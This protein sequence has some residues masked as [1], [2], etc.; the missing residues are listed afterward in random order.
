MHQKISQSVGCD[1]CANPYA[2]V[3]ASHRSADKAPSTWDGENQKECVILFEESRLVNVV[4]RVKEPHGTVHKVFMGKPS[5]PLHA[6]E[7][8]NHNASS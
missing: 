3:S 2:E 8:A 5:N 1:S 6:N 7:G 4:I